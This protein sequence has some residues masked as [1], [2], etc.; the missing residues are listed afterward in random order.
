MVRRAWAAAVQAAILA[1]C[2]PTFDWRQVRPEHS[3]AVA[4]FPCRPATHARQVRLGGAEVQMFVVACKAGGA[5]FSLGYADVGDAA[6]VAPALQAL[7]D[8]AVANLAGRARPD[9]KLPVPGAASDAA[10]ARL[11]IDGHL[12][13]GAAGEMAGAFFASGTRVFQA[14]VVAEGGLDAEPVETFFAGLEP[15]R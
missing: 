6:R 2:T 9:G 1:G 13:G 15:A 3:N 8:A 11:R 5:T 4:L 7:R 10:A 12:P 14:S